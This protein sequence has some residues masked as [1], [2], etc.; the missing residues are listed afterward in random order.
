MVIIQR[1]NGSYVLICNLSI[2]Q[3]LLQ[4]MPQSHRH[5]YHINILK[6]ATTTRGLISSMYIFAELA[7]DD[8]L[9]IVL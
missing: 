9:H 6:T 1:M 5:T 7:E 4:A 2:V 8:A 3:Q